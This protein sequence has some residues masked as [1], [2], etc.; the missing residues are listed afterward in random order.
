MIIVADHGH[1]LPQT[2]SRVND[3]KIPVLWLGGALKQKGIVINKTASQLD[4]A[5][6]L[7]QQTGFTTNTFPWS[8]NLLTGGSQWAYFC[9]NNGFGYVEPSKYFLFDNVGKQ[10]MD[11]NGM[12]L[13]TDFNKGKSIQQES[14][15]DY[16]EK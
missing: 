13:E 5:A 15:T 4:I 1:R 9:F 12:L 10:P 11:K 2:D 6:T 8:R 14:F 16:L 3:F 7:V